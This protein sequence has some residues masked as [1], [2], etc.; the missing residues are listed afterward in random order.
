[1]PAEP[2]GERVAAGYDDATREMNDPALVARTVDVLA[3]LAAGGRALEFAIGTGR[4]ALAL[5]GRGV[6]VHGIELSEP[7]VA[8]LRS[9]PGGAGIPVAIGDMATTRI[10]ADFTLVYLV[11]NTIS[12]LLTQREQVDCFRNAARHLVP[13][14]AFLVEV[15]VPRL[16]RLP[17]GERFV[18]FEVT[19]HHIGIDEYDV[20]QQRLISHHT[21]FRGDDVERFDSHHRFAWPAEYDLMAEMAGLEPA[22]RWADWDRSPFT[23]DSPSHV[24]VWRRPTT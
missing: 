20:A 4:I 1:M 13:G 19:S 22:F 3:D 15:E 21:W 6:E 12:N 17:E 2:W 7:M 23:S 5:V 14:G 8:H 11:F 10:D 24:S 16:R 9:K 18:P